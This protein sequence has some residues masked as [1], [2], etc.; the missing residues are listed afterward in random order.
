[1]TLQD[2]NNMPDFLTVFAVIVLSY[3]TYQVYQYRKTLLTLSLIATIGYIVYLYYGKHELSQQVQQ[4]TYTKAETQDFNNTKS[5]GYSLN[6]PGNIRNSNTKFK[7]EVYSDKAF[8]K[9][10]SMPYG[11]R[12]MTSLLHTYIKSGYNT[13][14]KILNRYA[15]SGDGN[16]NPTNY[17]ASVTKAANVKP[18]QTLS[19]SDFKNGNLMNVMYHMTKVEQGYPPNIQDLTEGFNMYVKEEQLN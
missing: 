16:N 12:A 5:L 4:I 19:T 7:G 8:K 6:N 17:V 9:F 10:S 1:M 2:L 13:V 18:D 3:V 15:P 11:F 14:N